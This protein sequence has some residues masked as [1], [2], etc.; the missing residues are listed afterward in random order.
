MNFHKST[1]GFL[2]TLLV[3]IVCGWFIG[4]FSWNDATAVAEKPKENPKPV[5]QI[6]EP[7]WGKLSS[8]QER[9][10]GF[11]ADNDAL[12]A[13]AV[14]GQRALA[15]S[16]LD[17][18]EA[19]L[20]RAGSRV[21]VLGRMDGLK[22]LRIGF[23]NPD[24]LADLLDGSEDQGYIFP[25]YTPNPSGG[26]VQDDAVPLGN[27][28]LAWLGL[29]SMDV[30]L[31]KGVK[32]AILDTGVVSHAALS[33]NVKNFMLV[34]ASANQSEWNGHGTAAASLIIGNSSTIPGAAPSATLSSYRIADDTGAS[35]SWKMAE[36]IMMAADAGNQIISISMG[37]YGNSVIL[38]QAIVYAQSKN[39]VVVA[40]SGNDSYGQSAYPA[41]YEG[42]IS[43][44]AV[45]A[46]NNHLLFSNQALQSGLAAPGWGVNAAYPG[47][48]ITSFSGTSASAPII[49]GSI[50]ATMSMNNLSAQQSVAM[51][52]QHVNEADAAGYD[53]NTGAGVVNLGRIAN[54]DTLNI[55]DGAVASNVI[56]PPTNTDSASV[57]VNIQNQ[58]TT[59][60]MNVPVQV[61]TPSGVKDLTVSS[62]A[63]G[64]VKSFTIPL[65]NSSFDKGASVS[66]SSR[67]S[68]QDAVLFNNQ[69]TTTYSPA[70]AP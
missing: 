27:Q 34:P 18:L 39:V 16:S 49:A 41:A 63:P 4:N 36:A 50:A 43:A 40:S 61:T 37:S 68:S 58:G 46:T 38:Q 23:L 9:K 67:I 20:K 51:I 65:S 70:P 35:D 7:A 57:Q 26:V 53:T 54:R 33:S 52:Y 32:I 69:R 6:P 24:D 30:T 64:A 5:I 31:G 59:T 47:D 2:L 56:S 22:A 25:A 60:L 62:L 44:V 8:S 14:P 19:F 15:F 45:D 12:E 1:L 66:V 11:R 28:L 3:A 42:V 13:G 55:Y 10:Q 29:T 21:S 17:A 48:R